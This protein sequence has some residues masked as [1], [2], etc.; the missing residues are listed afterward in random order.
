MEKWGRSA[1]LVHQAEL[2]V[3][4]NIGRDV[5]LRSDVVV[6]PLFA[7]WYAW[8]Q[9]ISPVTAALNVLN[10]H[11]PV[12]SSFLSSP[13]LHRAAAKNPEMLG[14]QFI[15][16][17]SERAAEID[18]LLRWTQK[19]QAE[20]IELGKAI[21]QLHALVRAEGSGLTMDALYA[22]VPAPLRGYVEL[23][24]DLYARPS[25]RLI[26]PLLYHSRYYQ[27]RHQSFALRVVEG[28]DRP[29][30]LSTP[31]LDE[32]STV[33]V[34][35]PFA[36]EDMDALYA[37]K[38]K[39]GSADALRERLGVA[40]NGGHW[41][42]LFEERTAPPVER[43]RGPGIRVR[44]FGHACLLVETAD[45]SV[46]VD[47]LVSYSVNAAPE[48]YTYEDLP[49]RIDYALL[50]HHH[51]D[52]VQLESLLQL[53]HRIDTVVVGNSLPGALQDPSLKLML[54]KLGFRKVVELAE[55][56]ALELPGGQ[57]V[58]LPFIGEHHE[59]AVRS[60]LG[61]RIDLLG[62]SILALAD[63]CNLEPEI[64]RQIRELTGPADILFLG[65]ECVGSPLTW[66]YGPLLPDRPNRA[67]DQSRRGRGSNYGEGCALVE[68]LGAKSVYLYAMGQEPWLRH[69]L[70]LAYDAT[71]P[72]IIESNR[73]MEWCRAHGVAAERLY[74]KHELVLN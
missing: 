73:L 11:V 38:S 59:L 10:R 3:P 26:E 25:F 27:E 22:R 74:G 15:A 42:A 17:G 68:Q 72:Q 19:E 1:P 57:I 31:R 66:S 44:Y 37:M 13:A 33:F 9:L 36:H 4:V 32:P 39:P 2:F 40:R 18:A 48:R 41:D 7:R 45:V 43:F 47:P 24:Y 65:M 35:R 14:G 16:Y 63:A 30:M 69:I 50:T 51:Q 23:E 64:Y 46:L 34:D 49:E 21:V 20:L 56:E 62:R 52:H 12:M 5:C 71:S 28:D 58:G 61:Y 55:L 53:R 29:F 70:G 60:R 54:R 8:V 67:H 6:E